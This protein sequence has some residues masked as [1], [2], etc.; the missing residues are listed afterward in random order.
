MKNQNPS[1][2]QKSTVETL[3]DR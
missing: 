1:C 2:F 3:L